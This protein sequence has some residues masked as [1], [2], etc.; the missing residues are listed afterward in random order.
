[1]PLNGQ[2]NIRFNTFGVLYAAVCLFYSDKCK[3][4]N[5]CILFYIAQFSACYKVSKFYKLKKM[6]VILT[7]SQQMESLDGKKTQNNK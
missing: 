2:K 5:V 6:R 1:M 4:I 3:Y 7:L